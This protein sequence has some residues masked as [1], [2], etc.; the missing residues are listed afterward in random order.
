MPSQTLRHLLF[1]PRNELY[2]PKPALSS[3]AALRISVL[4]A[5]D[6]SLRS[7]LTLNEVKGWDGM[8]TA[9]DR[10]DD[11]VSAYARRFLHTGTIPIFMRCPGSWSQG[12]S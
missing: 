1:L 8:M 10:H 3:F 6:P 4:G 9:R 2:Q 12:I 7:E 5:S 11:N